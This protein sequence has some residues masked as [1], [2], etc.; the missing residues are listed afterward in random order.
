M[1]TNF[2]AFVV[3]AHFESTGRLWFALGDGTVRLSLGSDI[4]VMQSHQG[5][6]LSACPHPSGSGLLTSGDD[7]RVVWSRLEGAQP[8]TTCL[9]DLPGQW[10]EPITASPISG[11]IA[12]SAGRNVHIRDHADPA[13]E[14]SFSL[15]R[16]A[17]GLAFDPKGRRLAVATYGGVSLW[18]PRVADQKSMWLRWAGSHIHVL[19]SPDGRFLLSSMQENQLH[20]WR[21]NDSRDMRMGGYPS[22]IHSLAF[23]DKGK[24]MLTSGAQGAV[25]WPFAGS[26]GPMNQEAIEIAYDAS[27]LITR[28]AAAPGRPIVAGGRDNGEVWVTDLS[29]GHPVVLSPGSGSPVSALSFSPDGQSLAFGR[30]NG[31]A[32]H[33][34]LSVAGF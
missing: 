30:E 27:S 13:L 3:F 26:N 6:V 2:D 21:L 33:L 11:L 22:K 28:V 19:W 10:I 5:A 4:L 20:G 17:S 8:V 9:V 23:V 34:N 18:Y 24:M 31:E 14:R 1:Q 12:F 32:Q 15:E 29:T 25:L 16:T 7:G